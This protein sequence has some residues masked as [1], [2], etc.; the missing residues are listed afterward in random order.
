[1]S[2]RTAQSIRHA[3]ARHT[4]RRQA[5]ADCEERRLHFFEVRLRRRAHGRNAAVVGEQRDAV[6]FELAAEEAARRAGEGR[7][8]A[9]AEARAFERGGLALLVAAVFLLGGA[10]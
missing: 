5:A 7:E 10:Q 8:P 3:A 6:A 2:S 4:S 1:P 9:L